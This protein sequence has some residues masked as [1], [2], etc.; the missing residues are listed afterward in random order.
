MAHYAH[1]KFRAFLWLTTLT[2]CVARLF[3]CGVGFLWDG[4]CEADGSTLAC[5]FGFLLGFLGG[6]C[7][8]SEALPCHFER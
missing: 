3:V 5:L 8:K 2:F 6:F 7:L 1:F 4:F